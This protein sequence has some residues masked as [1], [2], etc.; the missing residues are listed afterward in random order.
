M[1][2]AV[3]AMV[4]LLTRLSLCLLRPRFRRYII[5]CTSVG[6]IATSP[7]FVS[8][9]AQRLFS[10][11]HY[12][13]ETIGFPCATIYAIAIPHARRGFQKRFVHKYTYKRGQAVF[14]LADC[15]HALNALI[16][17]CTSLRDETHRKNA[18]HR[19]LRRRL[20]AIRTVYCVA[21]YRALS[22]IRMNLESPAREICN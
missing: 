7:S 1:V 8:L 17:A 19:Y 4:N 11:V 2:D 10:R 3:T 22:P 5:S 16:S 12:V 21:V 18:V 15:C 6:Q 13:T 9:N 20:H 14:Y